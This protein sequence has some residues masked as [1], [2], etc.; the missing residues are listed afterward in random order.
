MYKLLIVDDEELVRNAV[1]NIIDWNSINITE[2]MQAEDGELAL[3]IANQFRPDIILTDIRMPFMDG[4]EMARQV[5]E[6]LPET[7][8]VILTGHD[9]F[10]YAVKSIKLGI[11]D[12]IV[13]PISAE[14][15]L[16]TMNKIVRSLGHER[17]Q[18]LLQQ[19][20]R[21]QLRQSLPL[22]KEKM[23][24]QMITSKAVLD[25]QQ[26][27]Y[28]DIDLHYN[29]YTVCVFSAGVE[30][31]QGIEDFEVL[32]MILKQSLENCFNKSDIVFS[33]Y[34]NQHIVI[35]KDLSTADYDARANLHRLIEEHNQKFK[36]EYHCYINTGIGTT[37]TSISEL[38]LSYS[39]AQHVMS[40]NTALGND[41]IFDFIDLGYKSPE[42]VFPKELIEELLKTVYLNINCE[43]SLDKLIDFLA[44]CKNLTSYNLQLLCFEIINNINKMLLEIDPALDIREYETILHDTYAIKTIQN[45]KVLIGEFLHTIFHLFNDKKQS[46]KQLIVH[47]A[48]QYIEKNYASTD[49]N[50]N[51]VANNVFISPS[52]LSALF[53]KE[54]HMSFVDFITQIR[55]EKA[56][57]FLAASDARTYEV[58]LK[59][60]YQDPHYFSVCF[61]KQ[62]GL[63][64][65][66]YK[67]QL[68]NTQ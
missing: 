34:K 48:K 21:T 8:I 35:L 50:L 38:P 5:H 9:E 60:G 41:I 68:E 64:P 23:L 27:Q 26:M 63:S 4:L 17:S 19:K 42:F 51:T 58:A 13:K 45:F 20:M 44:G 15:L 3:D 40:Y 61:K 31:E 39:S 62:T 67:K 10:E 65:S 11:T 46:R 1:V 59:S 25:E 30:H 12:Y 7:K 22:L 49:L 54:T 55:I 37:V 52:Y 29:T 47:N 24:N 2:V 28:L 6:I 18:K 36:D 57:E 53:R 16:Q 33:N 32:N 14:N 66:E 56:K 43:E